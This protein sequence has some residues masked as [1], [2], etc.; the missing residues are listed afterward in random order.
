MKKEMFEDW[1]ENVGN[2]LHD[3][4]DDE[5]DRRK[6]AKMVFS[7]VYEPMIYMFADKLHC[8]EN[9]LM[10]E[11]ENIEDGISSDEYIYKR[12]TE[13]KE[14]VNSLLTAT[15]NKYGKNEETEEIKKNKE[16]LYEMYKHHKET[17]EEYA[18][19]LR[20]GKFYKRQISS[21]ISI[22][23]R[24]HD[25]DDEN[26]NEE[27]MTYGELQDKMQNIIQMSKEDLDKQ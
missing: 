21:L 6:Y 15:I 5:K 19:Y 13:E 20:E 9:N 3:F 10:R 12:A 17:A 16:F 25:F 22:A 7:S 1:Y 26:N 14:K 27:C 18:Y 4:I 24:V 8:V 23:Q 11:L 2:E